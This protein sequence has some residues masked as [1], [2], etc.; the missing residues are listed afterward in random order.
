MAEGFWITLMLPV[1][2]LVGGIFFLDSIGQIA[3]PSWEP[4]GE[5][6]YTSAIPSLQMDHLRIRE[7][8]DLPSTIWFVSCWTIV[9]TPRLLAL[10]QLSHYPHTTPSPTDMNN[11]WLTSWMGST[12]IQ[13]PSTC[14]WVHR[15][16]RWGRGQ[17]RAR[18][19]SG[20]GELKFRPAF[21]CQENVL[22]LNHLALHR[23]VGCWL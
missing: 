16:S 9:C 19:L 15:Q 8:S 4:F 13:H 10:A 2:F 5:I 18:I 11:W 17:M 21:H 1:S 22:W 20:D 14:V 3:L 6:F 7:Q 12:E 23:H